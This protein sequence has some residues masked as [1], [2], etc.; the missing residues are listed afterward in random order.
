MEKEKRIDVKRLIESKNNFK[1]SYLL[2]K[3]YAKNNHKYEEEIYEIPFKKFNIY[4]TN[5]PFSIFLTQLFHLL[6]RIFHSPMEC[7]S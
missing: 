2:Y 1:H 3:F 6:C 7:H 5:T 4:S